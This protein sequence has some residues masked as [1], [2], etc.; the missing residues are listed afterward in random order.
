MMLRATFKRYLS[1]TLKYIP[2]YNSAYQDCIHFFAVNDGK[3]D[4]F[5]NL[6]YC[7]YTCIWT[8]KHQLGIKSQL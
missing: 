2:F 1:S 4:I 3:I 8:S 5:R 6:L 7:F